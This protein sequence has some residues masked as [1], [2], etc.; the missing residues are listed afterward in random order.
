MGAIL[1]VWTWRDQVLGAKLGDQHPNARM[2]AIQLES[3]FIATSNIRFLSKL[4]QLVQATRL[5]YPK[6]EEDELSIGV[7]GSAA[8]G[9]DML[10]ASAESVRRT[11][12]VTIGLI[13]L[14]L[15]IVYRGRCWSWCRW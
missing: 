7:S 3:D 1:D 11:E 14:I 4:E 10:R 8:V 2:I 6:S 5:K 12:W 15:A 13:L 9:G